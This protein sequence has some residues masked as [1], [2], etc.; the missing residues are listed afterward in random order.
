MK[1]KRFKRP[2]EE[3]R[4]GIII[5]PYADEWW[6]N[7]MDKKAEVLSVPEKLSHGLTH[8]QGAAHFQPH[9]EYKRLM[10]D[11]PLLQPGDIVYFHDNVI[12]PAIEEGYWMMEDGEEVIFVPY[13]D[14][15]CG[16]RDGEIIGI[17]QNCIV[18]LI[19]EIPSEIKTDSGLIIKPNLGN[20]TQRG[21]LRAKGQD[22]EGDYADV[23][24]GDTIVWSLKKAEKHIPITIEGKAYARVR[25]VNVLGVTD[26]V[27]DEE[28]EERKRLSKEWETGMNKFSIAI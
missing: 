11:E 17:G 28:L 5:L 1:I 20:Q 24:V 25:W 2:N 21:I 8:D 18:E 13:K 9:R 14:I 4:N 22:P 6:N 27:S 7:E 10:E 26:P 19:P 12:A 23:N 3:N 15:H 16:V